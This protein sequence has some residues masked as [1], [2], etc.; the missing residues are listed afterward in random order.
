MLTSWNMISGST[1]ISL[2]EGF[3]GGGLETKLPEMINQLLE[4]RLGGRKFVIH[5]Q[6]ITDIH[7]NTNLPPGLVPISDPKYTY[8]LMGILK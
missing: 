7:L 4:E 3:D 5:L 8:I 1:Y 2:K 6:P